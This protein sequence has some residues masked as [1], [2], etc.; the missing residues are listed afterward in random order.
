[1][2]NQPWGIYEGARFTM[3]GYKDF[4]ARAEISVPLTKTGL[5]TTSTKVLAKLEGTYP[6]LAPLREC[7]DAP[8]SDLPVFDC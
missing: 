5:P 8:P 6:Q 4:L 2:N 1:M 7:M 3:D